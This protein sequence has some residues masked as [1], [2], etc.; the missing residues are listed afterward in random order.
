MDKLVNFGDSAIMIP[1]AAAITAWLVTGHAWR[2]AL[3]WCLLFIAGVGLVIASKIVFLGWGSGIHSI[4]FKAFSGHAM[5]TTAVIPVMFYLLLQ[6]S[7]PLMRVCGTLLGILFG[8]LMGI[9]V[10]TFNF[11]S[12]SEA[13]AGCVIG[14]SVSLGFIRMSDNLP[15]LR[16]NRWL[17]PCSILVFFAVW[18]VRP[19][20]LEH[21]ITD[22]ALHLSGHAE[23]YSW[24]TWEL[25]H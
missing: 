16:L 8:V 19:A 11:H 1:A 24:T 4:D 20:S 5:R 22:M 6:R 25:A 12:V 10:A 9:C 2:M 21:W 15:M 14:G 3:W 18:Y 23:P 7:P 13:M 17:V